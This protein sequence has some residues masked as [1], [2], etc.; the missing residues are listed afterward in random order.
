M[1]FPLHVFKRFR[2]YLIVK[3]LYKCNKCDVIYASLCKVMLFKKCRMI[4]L[5]HC[6]FL[7]GDE[8]HFSAKFIFFSFK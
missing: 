3:T 1:Y 6:Y 8:S 7:G 5:Q 4:R 2:I